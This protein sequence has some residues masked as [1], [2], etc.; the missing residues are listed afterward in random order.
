MIQSFCKTKVITTRG[1]ITKKKLILSNSRSRRVFLRNLR[2]SLS[3]FLH[4]AYLTLDT[5][6]QQAYITL[7]MGLSFFI[8]FAEKRSILRWCNF[9]LCVYFAWNFMLGRI[10]KVTIQEHINKPNS[11]NRRNL[12]IINLQTKSAGS[13]NSVSVGSWYVALRK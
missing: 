11:Q 10:C 9:I 4:Q 6:L 3:T 13:E 1:F 5:F 2:K 8:Y 12:S 7:D